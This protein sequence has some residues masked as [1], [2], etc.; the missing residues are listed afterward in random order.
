MQSGDEDS[1]AAKV[2]VSRGEMNGEGV[3]MGEAGIGEFSAELGASWVILEG[4]EDLPFHTI[5]S[6]VLLRLIVLPLLL[7]QRSMLAFQRSLCTGGLCAS[8]F[9]VACDN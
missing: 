2:G 7:L 8:M 5:V 3:V 9:W 4:R 6:G 1:K